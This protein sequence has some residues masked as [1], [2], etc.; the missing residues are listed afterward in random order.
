MD[1]FNEFFA[2]V[3]DEENEFEKANYNDERLNHCNWY[4]IDDENKKKALY[5]PAAY[6]GMKIK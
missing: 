4:I 2:T 6:L 3:V 5:I 1:K